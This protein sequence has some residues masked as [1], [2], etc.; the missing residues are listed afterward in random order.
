MMRAALALRCALALSAWLVPFGTSALAQ[1]RTLGPRELRSGLSFAGQDIRAMQN[2]DVANPGM[3]WVERGEKLWNAAVGP[4][5]RTCA[6]CHGDARVSMR[7][8]A[9]RY[10]AH[11]ATTGA[12]FDVESRIDDCRARRQQAP[13]FPRESEDLLAL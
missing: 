10:P 1:E 7:G 9:A 4:D 3:L 12:L 5:A 11:D 13:P 6:S 8:V 2:D